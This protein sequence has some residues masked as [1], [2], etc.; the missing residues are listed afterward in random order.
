ESA[1]ECSEPERP[2]VRSGVRRNQARAASFGSGHPVIHVSSKTTSSAI[3]LVAFAAL[4]IAIHLPF[5]K[6]PFFWDELGQFVPA[7][8]DI[9]RSGAWIPHSTLPNVHPP[10][11]MAYLALVWKIFGYSIAA[12]RVAML[13]VASAGVLFSFQLA[14]R[15][16]RGVAGTPAFA[17]AVF[18][19]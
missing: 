10:A 7:A 16:S 2:A 15:L 18:L 4:V 6:L 1:G 12:G 8:L 11:V 19:I 5:L 9:L 13:V 3:F 17:A 14:I